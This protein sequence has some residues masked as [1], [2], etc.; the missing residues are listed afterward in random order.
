MKFS[1]SESELD[2]ESLF[3]ESSESNTTSVSQEEPS[4]NA[5]SDAIKVDTIPSTHDDAAS[6]DNTSTSV[7]D[8]IISSA[9]ETAASDSD[10]ASDADTQKKCP[11]NHVG[12]GTL[13]VAI[14]LLYIALFAVIIFLFFDKLYTNHSA[15]SQATTIHILSQSEDLA[16]RPDM[17]D[18]DFLFQG[19][20][21]GN[22]S[23]TGRGSAAS[24]NRVRE[25][26]DMLRT[27][28]EMLKNTT[29]YRIARKIADANIPFK[30]PLKKIFR[31]N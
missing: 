24:L 29:S 28:M 1:S 26:N 11:V 22:P 6:Y 4:E 13:A 18:P 16:N 27:S 20:A 8:N 21:M 14:A 17:P 25:E 31:K 10:G 5:V 19:L 23:V 3:D 9:D 12:N 7:Q 2:K 15:N 30:E